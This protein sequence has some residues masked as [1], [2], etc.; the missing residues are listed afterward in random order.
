MQHC[1]L[2]APAR[3]ALL[4][5][6]PMLLAFQLMH[7]LQ[8][9]AALMLALIQN[10]SRAAGVPLL[11]CPFSCLPCAAQLVGSTR[12]LGAALS[13]LTHLALRCRVESVAVAPE[14]LE[15]LSQ[16][17]AALAHVQDAR[18]PSSASHTCASPG[19]P[20]V[21]HAAAATTTLRPTRHSASL[22]AVWLPLQLRRL[23]LASLRLAQFTPRLAQALS[24]LTYLSCSGK[25]TLRV[26][27]WV[28]NEPGCTVAQAIRLLAGGAGLPCCRC[29]HTPAAC[30]HR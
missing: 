14:F 27:I 20:Y 7:L 24:G 2:H 23:E 10:I 25:N 28:G 15:S 22:Y 11:T 29:T 4:S 26:L 19:C 3:L 30:N 1:A 6:H 16:V 8:L 21:S 17:G 9:L 12:E 13:H 5:T 18:L